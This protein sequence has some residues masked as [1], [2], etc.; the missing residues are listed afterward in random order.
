MEK[1]KVLNKKGKDIL[2]C[3]SDYD[4]L[5]SSS[6]ELFIKGLRKEGFFK[7]ISSKDFLEKDYD[8]LKEFLLKN[9]SFIKDREEMNNDIIDKYISEFNKRDGILVDKSLIKKESVISITKRIGLSKLD[10]DKFSIYSS[11]FVKIYLDS[12]IKYKIKEK[13]DSKKTILGIKLLK[14]IGEVYN[15]EKFKNLY[16]FDVKISVPTYAILN[17]INSGGIDKFNKI[18]DKYIS[19]IEECH[20]ELIDYIKN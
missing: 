17:L 7:Q 5:S 1:N 6:K 16:N 2:R 4:F 8:E 18:L 9:K 10:F 11:D 15:S 14:S 3:K 20:K 19:D 13:V 12:I